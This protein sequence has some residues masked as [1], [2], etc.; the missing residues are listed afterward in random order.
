MNRESKIPFR[1]SRSLAD[2]KPGDIHMLDI[3]GGGFNG[4][5]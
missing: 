3:S 4:S 1:P 5:L 2:Q